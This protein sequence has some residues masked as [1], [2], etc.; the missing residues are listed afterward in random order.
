MSYV[1]YALHFIVVKVISTLH[2]YNCEFLKDIGERI[3]TL[4]LTFA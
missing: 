4:Q 2:Q 3:G 1:N